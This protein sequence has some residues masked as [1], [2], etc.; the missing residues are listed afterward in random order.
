MSNPQSIEESRSY[1]CIFNGNLEED[2]V[3][4]EKPDVKYHHHIDYAFERPKM[5]A[6]AIALRIPW[7][8][9]TKTAT[10]TQFYKD[11]N[12]A[13]CLIIQINMYPKKSSF[14]S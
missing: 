11:T 13:D 1:T 9:Y 3:S 12:I 2:Q 5:G 7:A 8:Y 6:L 14:T 10:V 4:W